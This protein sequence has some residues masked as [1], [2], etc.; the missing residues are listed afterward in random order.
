[1]TEQDFRVHLARGHETNGIE[2]KGPGSSTD[3][4]FLAKI[5]RA[6]LAMANRRDGGTIIIGVEDTNLSPIGLDDDQLATWSYDDVSSR[7]NEYASPNIRFTLKT[8]EF[9]GRRFAI[10]Q[11]EQFDDIPV[12]CVKDYAGPHTKGAPTL[13]RGA[14]YVRARHKPETSEIPSAEEMRELLDLAIDLGVRKFL[15]RAQ[16]AGLF[17]PLSERH[18]SLTDEELFERQIKEVE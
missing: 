10:L 5:V 16:K 1:M 8:P 3:K 12:L 11:V 13:R 9:N 15:T 14:C 18:T 7:I 4:A 17:S 6:A 2:F